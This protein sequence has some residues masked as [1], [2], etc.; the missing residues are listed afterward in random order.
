MTA[1][2][3]SIE[4]KNHIKLLDNLSPM[5]RFLVLRAPIIKVILSLILLSNPAIALAHAGH[6]DEF[7]GDAATQNTGSYCR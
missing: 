3:M 5:K 1:L 7:K 4:S 2:L 6:G